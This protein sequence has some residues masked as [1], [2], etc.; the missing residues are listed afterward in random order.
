[1]TWFPFRLLVAFFAV[2]FGQA[3]SGQ[4]LRPTDPIASIDGYPVFMGELNLLL[5]KKLGARDPMDVSGDVRRASASLIARQHLAMRSLR[6]QGG[7]SLQS[8]LEKDWA[9][10]TAELKRAGLSPSDYAKRY[11]SDEVSLR[12]ARDW[13]SA[14]KTYLKSRVTESN[15]KRLFESSPERYAGSRWDV[16]HLFL[17]IDRS[18]PHSKEIAIQTAERLAKQFDAEDKESLAGRFAELAREQSAGATASE[19]GRIGWV[20][21]SGDLP[22]LVMAAIRK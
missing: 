7:R 8:I 19:G 6:T 4:D 20:S 18:E 2:G 11:Q 17:P 21:K 10:F 14:W 16:S 22:G 15:L 5:M 12:A 3:V 1:M 13:E 9:A